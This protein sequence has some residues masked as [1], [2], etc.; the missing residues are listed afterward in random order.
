MTSRQYYSS[1]SS[2]QYSL[3]STSAFNA[4]GILRYS[5]KQYSKNSNQKVN[6]SSDIGERQ[7]IIVWY[8]GPAWLVNRAWK[9][10]AR[11]AYNGW[12]FGIRQYNVIHSSSTIFRYARRGNVKGLQKL[13][14]RRQASPFDC[15]ENGQTPLHV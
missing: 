9:F 10:H 12:N 13:F 14:D 1:S 7:E 6:E 5:T 4:F 11:K 2:R 15:D 3:G 8:R